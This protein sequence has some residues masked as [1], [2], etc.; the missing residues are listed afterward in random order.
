[1]PAHKV[2]YVHI[3]TVNHVTK[4]KPDP[5]AKG[6]LLYIKSDNKRGQPGE[7]RAGDGAFQKGKRAKTN[8]TAL[9]V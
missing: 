5:C 8:T 2:L 4:A 7:E 3:D 1:M 9:L 6:Q